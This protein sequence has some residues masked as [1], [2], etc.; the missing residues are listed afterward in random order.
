MEGGNSDQDRGVLRLS[1]I[2]PT[3][4]H[5]ELLERLLSALA[6][7]P[8]RFKPA[9]TIIVDDS[10]DG[11]GTIA[12]IARRYRATYVTNQSRGYG[13]ACNTGAGVATQPML[14]FLNQDSCPASSEFLR[15]TL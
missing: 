12:P 10:H 7:A 6:G 15:V 2:I 5:P 3:Y 9:E 8:G 1:V 11:L 13:S 4:R 14:I